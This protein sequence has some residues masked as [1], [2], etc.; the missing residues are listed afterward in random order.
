M[1]TRPASAHSRKAWDSGDL[2]LVDS[3]STA[4]GHS[5]IVSQS[6]GMEPGLYGNNK[7]NQKQAQ[8]LS[9]CGKVMKAIR[10]LWATR[11]TEETKGDRELHVKTTLR[12]LII[13]IVFLSVLCV[14]TF[15]MTSP[16]MYYYTKAMTDLFVDSTY[17]GGGS[18]RTINTVADFWKFAKGPLIDALYWEKWYNED[19]IVGD[20]YIYYENKLLGLPRMRQLKVRNDSCLVH[21]DFKSSIKQCFDDY[22][23]IN[24]DRA[25][26]FG[27]P[28]EIEKAFE[29]QTKKELDGSTYW[30]QLTSYSG[31]GY[32]QDLSKT[33]NETTR[34]IDALFDNLWIDRGT[35][36]VFIDFT[37]YNANINLFCVVRLVVEFPPTGGALSSVQFSTVKLIRYVNSLDYFVMACEAIFVLFI[38]Y[39][40]IEETIEIKKHKFSY[41]K[42]F[43]NIL[44]MLVIFISTLC[45]AF[46]VYRTIAVS[47]KLKS[48][49]AKGDIYAQ[50]EFLAF[51]QVQFNNAIAIT[52]FLAWIKI[53]KYISFNKTMT[54]LSSTL[55]KCAKDLAGF[56]VMFFI[57]FLAFTQLGYLIFGTQIKDFSSFE[58]SFFTLFRIILGDFDFVQLEAADRV[59]GPIFF[60][61]YVFFVFF[62][63]LNMFLAIINDTYSEVK[64]DIANQK[65]EFEM[66]DYFKRGYQ[67]MVDKLNFKR[68][69]IVDIQRALQS[70]D[71]NQDNHLDFDEWRQD[72]KSRGYADGEIEAMFAKYDVDG[73]R[74]LDEEEQKRMQADLSEQKAALTK[75][76][77]EL[78]EKAG[79]QGRHC[80]SRM[81]CQDD[82]G[83]DSD[84]EDNGSK[85]SR[86]GR[87]TN[88]V[89]C[90]EF[91]VLS[92]RVDRMEH[93]IGSIVSKIDAVLVKLEAM[94]KAKIKRRETMAKMLDSITEST[95]NSD[96]MKRDQMEKLVREELERWDSE[97]SI[98]QPN[99]RGGSPGSSSG[100]GTGGLRPR[101]SSR[102]GSGQNLANSHM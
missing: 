67:R 74:V 73:D 21:P 25:T 57:I 58:D 49:L 4:G 48:L 95:G 92:R 40:I 94:E 60:F 39:Y 6:C 55:G 7:V 47:E 15:G 70:A 56:A 91:T 23:E 84:D 62:V 45:I 36:V 64:G 66:G 9:C 20:G 34:I 52:V 17:S 43:W 71:I 72:M 13:Y 99:G 19:P 100:P 88:G 85:L 37:V 63:L 31:G 50:F 24:E 5:S 28:A 89:S 44:D 98:S 87:V 35:R 11:D 68:D 93:S 26:T 14:I 12:E 86:S 42:G 38:L 79:N 102:P 3:S 80:S 81:S 54:Q 77:D 96:E 78:E 90:E 69:K 65:S 53:F 1:S 10:S 8:N 32:V 2:G 51:C 83:E 59:L 30:G 22:S 16:S 101:S 33:K 82:S 41:F 76:Y 46:N 29:Y 97:A 27:K 18:F 75:E 61:L